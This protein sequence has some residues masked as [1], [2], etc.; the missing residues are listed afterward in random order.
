LGTA[1]VGYASLGQLQILMPAIGLAA[2]VM[3]VPSMVMTT[4]LVPDSV[5]ATALGAFNGAGSLGFIFGPLAGGLV[6]ERVAASS[7]WVAGYRAAFVAAGAAE[8]ACVLVAI[9]VV[10]RWSESRSQ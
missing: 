3:F 8:I 7:G 4:D 9:A 6:S 5:R 2:A 1:A 10:W